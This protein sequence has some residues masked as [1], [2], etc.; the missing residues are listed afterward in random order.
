MKKVQHGSFKLN[1]VAVS[2]VLAL[3]AQ[4][5][6]NT[7][8]ANGG[9]G[10][11]NDLLGNPI[12]VE[13]YF[14]SS[15]QGI[16]PAFD[17]ATH[18]YSATN[19]VDTGLPIRKFVDPLAG[20]DGAGIPLAVTEKWFNTLT[21]TQ[22]TD[23]YYEL[24]IVDYRQNMHSDL[25][26]YDPVTAAP[27]NQP[28]GTLLRGFVQIETPAI[29]A[30]GLKDAAGA[31]SEH[32]ALTHA[33]GVTPVLDSLGNQVYAV[34]KPHYLGPIIVASRGTAVRIKY[35]NYL[36]IG[37]AGDLPLPVDESIAG[38]GPT[39]DKTGKPVKF[40][41]NRVAIHWHGGDT[42]WISDGTPHQWVAPAGETAAYAAGIGKGASFQNVP[43]MPDPGPGA[44]TLYFPNDLSARLMF[45]HDHASGLTK[46]NVYDGVA[47]GYV[48][49]DPV[50][51]GL[52]SKGVIPNTLLGVGIPL[53]IQDKTFVPKNIGP[54]NGT[55]F[56]QTVTQ[57]QDAKWDLNHWGKPG[58][59]WYPHVYEVNQDPNSSNG[60]NAV[61]RWDWGPWFW[62]VF[63]AQYSLPSGAYGDVTETPEAFMDTPVVNGQAYPTMT[64][65]P[66]P[67]RFRILAAP[68]D[69]SLNLN[70]FEAVDADGVVCDA[71]A[72]LPPTVAA[73]ANGGTLPL[74]A[75]TEVKMVSAAPGL[76]LPATWPMDGRAGGAPDPATAGPDIVQIGN[77]AGFLPAP[78]VW[79]AQPITYEQ[80]VR[81]MTLLSVLNHG[82]L[83]GPAER[84]DVI[85]DFSK[86]AGKTLILYNDAPAPMPGYDPRIDYFTGV[87]DQSPNGGAYDT[88]EGYGPNTRT[89][90][91][92]K[93][94]PAS[95]T[96][97]VAFDTAKLA[98]ALPAAYAASQPAPLI[99][100]A[101]YNP[102]F[103]TVDVNHYAQIYTGTPQQPTL[104]WTP[105][106]T[107]TVTSISVIDGGIGFTG[108]P[109]VV[110]TGGGCTSTAN[111][112]AATATINAAL[113]TVTAITVTKPGIGC[114]SAPTVSLTGGGGYAATLTVQT[115]ATKSLPI[116]NKAIQELFDPIY[117]RMNAT[118]A[119]EIRLPNLVT[120]VNATTVPLAYID[121]P[122]VGIDDIKDGET[123]I[124]KI[125]H[126]GVDTH[127]VHFHLVNVQVLNRVEWAGVVKGPEANE[128]GWKETLRMNP[129]EDVFVAVKAV[130]PVTPFG[131]PASSRLLDP[132]QVAG[133]QLGFTQI[134]FTTG[135]A[136]IPPYANVV[137]SFD[138]EYVWHCHIL[139]H[140]EFDFMRPFVFH[141]NVVIPDAPTNVTLT[142][143]TLTWTDPTPVGGFDAFGVPTAGVAVGGTVP[144]SNPKNEIGFRIMRSTNGT[145]YTQAAAVP[146]NVTSWIDPAP[147]ANARY[148]VA[149][150]NVAGVA[151]SAA[152]GALNGLAA[153]TALISAAPA[154]VANAR[155]TLNWNAFPGTVTGYRVLLNGVQQGANLSTATRTYTSGTLNEGTTYTFT[156]AP[157]TGA[158]SSITVTTP[159]SVPKAP[160]TLAV[161]A[162]AATATA[163]VTTL[164][165]VDAA[166]NETGYQV[167]SAIA[168]GACSAV[169]TWANLT[170]LPPL[171]TSYIDGSTLYGNSYCYRVSAVNLAGS[172]AWLTT[173]NAVAMPV[174]P[175][176][177][178]AP[179]TAPTGLT[180]TLSGSTVTLNWNAVAGATS[181]I[182]TVNGV[183][184]T[185]LSNSTSFAASVTGQTVTVVAVTPTGNT[186][187]ASLYNGIAPPVAF[188]A[189]SGVN[190]GTITL[191]WANNPLN[192]N[193][194]TGITAT[195]QTGA[196]AIASAQFPA[197][198]TGAT[199]T[200]LTT[201]STYTFTLTANS[202][203]GNAAAVPV[204]PAVAFTAIAK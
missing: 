22:T 28:H 172:S 96:A 203:V 45:Y 170:T 117:G 111:K 6:A 73:P 115:T 26:D 195:W 95:V 32:I 142:G 91:Q 88:P 154:T 177:V 122:V 161:A 54:L 38:G 18:G 112:P 104:Q 155:V 86:Y 33:D 16:Q 19:T 151:T 98:A 85:V 148:Q 202:G 147:V 40:T 20:V 140:E 75:C 196:G 74:A 190:P 120:G 124:W 101:A 144:T 62:P 84:A 179:G 78:A 159:T 66:I 50:E 174:A 4:F 5:A 99:P 97:P 80:N 126:N 119:V 3:A 183:P 146:A 61:G 176:P 12:N 68:N 150:Y 152:T 141:P 114:T 186:A 171:T 165:W 184:S 69:R 166:F 67:Y 1:P 145:T 59:L 153:T 109:T 55:L 17:L 127:P 134:D 9:W 181:Y 64:V 157:L 136:P 102:A 82:L 193:N 158:S 42:P 7:S 77:E 199:I 118:L 160:T 132:T 100:E 51:Q 173:A 23:D 192:V 57:S 105:N 25:V 37:A 79:K 29:V 14:A 116:I 60:T 204:A 46:L 21:N 15:P 87:G 108:V 107:Q 180:Q 49:T 31:A 8:L 58:D 129:L 182:V 138:N 71:T 72:A 167:Q 143:A 175:T 123:Q 106:G 164:T 24:A 113:Q 10:V 89:V 34:H 27:L 47:A 133:S 83:L 156:V 178:A 93:V 90:M 131:L 70:F 191:T 63:P 128:I 2:L 44:G 168:T 139:G 149:A 76:G 65:D 201:G 194:V 36:P 125:T 198:S 169:A 121:Q 43:D 52:V 81:R 39:I 35:T 41:Q 187:A 162:V 30:G 188:T 137:S 110:F 48:I 185:V 92:F 197:S 103:G 11:N 200:G 53:V 94:N 163:P 56:G 135:L 13:T 130:H 189:V